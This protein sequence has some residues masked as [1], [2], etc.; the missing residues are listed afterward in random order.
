[1]AEIKNIVVGVDGS[2]SSR[3]A[4]RWAYDEAAHHGATITAVATWHPPTLPTTPPPAA[5]APEGYASQPEK[6]AHELLAES[7]SDLKDQQPTVDVTSSVEEGH[8][9]KVLIER[10]KKAD[11]LVLGSHGHGGFRGMLL[12][13]VSQHVVGHADCPVVIIR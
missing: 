5:S 7:I 3:E 11:L 4:L 8:P 10:S 1:M 9:A 12:G 13:S 6:D 2:K